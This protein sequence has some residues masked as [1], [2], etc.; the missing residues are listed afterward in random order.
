[1]SRKSF[2]IFILG[3]LKL[4]YL[5][6]IFSLQ[7]CPVRQGMR[8]YTGWWS[9]GT[10]TLVPGFPGGTLV[11]ENLPASGGDGGDLGLIP[12]SGRSPGGGHYNP[13]RYSC[14]ENPMGRGVWQAV[15]Q[16]VAKSWT[17]LKWF[18]KHT[19][20]HTTEVTT[21][22]HHTTHTYTTT[23]TPL[24]PNCFHLKKLVTLWET[25][26][27]GIFTSWQ[28]DFSNSGFLDRDL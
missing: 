9:D 1:M 10:L 17:R 27:N 15:V 4:F 18:H 16:W 20:I 3:Y 7:F 25:D 5:R 14:L 11:A 23:T 6:I 2:R 24:V 22:T 21:H 26:Y 28:L 8:G 12:G 13:L 19:Y